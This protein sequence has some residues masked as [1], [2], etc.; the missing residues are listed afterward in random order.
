MLAS[1]MFHYRY[2]EDRR[3]VVHLCLHFR[4][5]ELPAVLKI[6]IQGCLC[7]EVL[8]ARPPTVF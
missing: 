5:R 2:R 7:L 4:L 6:G 8:A 1:I 3:V